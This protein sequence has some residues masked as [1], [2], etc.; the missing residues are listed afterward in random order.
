MAYV[1]EYGNFGSEEFLYF[2]TL[3]LNDRQWITLIELPD[4]DKLPYVRGVITGE[5]VS[6]F[7]EG[8]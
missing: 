6:E 8:F 5:D 3:A 4:S 2:D 7:E 1:T